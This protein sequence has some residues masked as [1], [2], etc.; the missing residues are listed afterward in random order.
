M[1]TKKDLLY[2]FHHTQERLKERYDIE[3]NAKDYLEMCE[4][5]A[6]RKNVKLVSEEEQKNDIQ[7]IYHIP[8]KGS[9]IRVVWSTTS[10]WIKTVLP[11]AG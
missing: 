9:T 8:F 2:S 10:N 1:K 11:M 6:Y 4:R 3:I 5:I 7:Q